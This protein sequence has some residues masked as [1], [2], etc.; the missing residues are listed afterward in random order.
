MSFD[1]K[2]S[3]RN[4]SVYLNAKLK[5][6]FGEWKND[7]RIDHVVQLINDGHAKLY[8]IEALS[9]MVGFQ[10]RSKF[11]DAFKQRQGVTPS[12]YIKTKKA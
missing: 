10:S 4:L 9:T 2:I 3:E 5:K 12:A 11:I 7:Q 6:T 1:L 8:T